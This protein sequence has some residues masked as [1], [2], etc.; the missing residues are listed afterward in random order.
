VCV[1]IGIVL[2]LFLV[3]ANGRIVSSFAM[4]TRVNVVGNDHL[5][6]GLT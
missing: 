2:L 6:T 5:R 4:Q 1:V 3:Y